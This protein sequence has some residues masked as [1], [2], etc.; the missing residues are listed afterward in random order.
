[1]AFHLGTALGDQPLLLVELLGLLGETCGT[2]IDHPG[3]LIDFGLAAIQTSFAVGQGAFHLANLG[4]PVDELLA[5]AGDGQAMLLACPL[6]IEKMTANLLGLSL[7]LQPGRFQGV[8]FLTGE[9]VDLGQVLAEP[10]PRLGEPGQGRVCLLFQLGELPLQLQHLPTGRRQ[11]GLAPLNHFLDLHSLAPRQCPLLAQ[12]LSLGSDGPPHLL[13]LVAG[14]FEPLLPGF[15]VVPGRVDRLLTLGKLLGGGL[16]LLFEIDAAG[17]D[18][19]LPGFEGR[20]GFV[21]QPGLLGGGAV[22]G[23]QFLGPA[24]Q[25]I[26]QSLPR[27]LRPRQRRFPL[28]QCLPLRF[29]PGLLLRRLGD[30]RLGNGNLFTV[31]GGQSIAVIK[32]LLQLG[33]LGG[34]AVLLLAHP[35]D[36]LV[37]QGAALLETAKLLVVHEPFAVE[38]GPLP[39]AFLDPLLEIGFLGL[40]AGS[41]GGEQLRF[42][43]DLFPHS[44]EPGTEAR[45]HGLLSLDGGAAP[46]QLGSA[47]FQLGILP[48]NPLG[49]GTETNMGFVEV[50]SLLFQLGNVAG[51]PLR[52][53]GQLLRLLV[54]LLL[55]V[56]EAGSQPIEPDQVGPVLLLVAVERL[57]IL[58]QLL[59]LGLQLGPK[60]IA[61]LGLLR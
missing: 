24:V 52:P 59:L 15:E 25:L 54:E 4:L 27:L 36:R 53:S 31:L 5:K 41:L 3:L 46:R 28:R 51:Q 26:L 29:D 49:L 55:P 35:G 48:G 32:P 45:Q 7:A 10:F 22:A 30:P 60:P 57:P 12:A 19:G 34:K 13:Q 14:D 38:L 18:L 2:G 37:E 6:E 56:V 9:S 23:G 8:V 61:F 43:A 39:P 33:F 47:L 44:L 40:E 42:L 16:L 1:M 50:A 58:D 21:E 17:I 20:P 11:L